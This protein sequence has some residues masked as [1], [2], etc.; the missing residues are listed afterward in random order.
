MAPGRYGTASA[1]LRLARVLEQHGWTR[2]AQ[3][4]EA[5]IVIVAG[6]AETIRWLS[7][8]SATGGVTSAAA[9]TSGTPAVISARRSN[10]S[11]AGHRRSAGRAG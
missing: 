2:A 8:I 3:P 4:G 1:G 7:E 10:G 6:P 11:G 9:A 5:E